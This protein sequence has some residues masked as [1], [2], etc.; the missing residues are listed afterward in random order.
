MEDSAQSLGKEL[1]EKRKQLGYSLQDVA[2]YTRIRKV[3][4]ES[5]E[6]GRFED[7]PGQAYVTGFVRVYAR[8]LGLDSNDILARLEVPE[9]ADGKQLSD[10]VTVEKLPV[11]AEPQPRSDSGWGAFVLGFIIVIALGALFYFMPFSLDSGNPQTA[12]ENDTVTQ[13]VSSPVQPP[14]GSDVI[15]SPANTESETIPG[16]EVDQESSAGVVLPVI[17]AQGSVLSL[18]ALAESSLIIYV[19]DHAPREYELNA[20]LELT[21]EVKKAVRV[22]L[23]QPGVARFW[24]GDQELDLAELNVFQ[25]STVTGE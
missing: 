1:E 21:W 13:G 8:H 11:P 16:L 5:M 7:L 17:P 12:A 18:L 3:Y 6:Q 25:L 23:A 19:D 14:E 20:G 15:N 10:P 9:N 22:E 2:D 24:L 4:L